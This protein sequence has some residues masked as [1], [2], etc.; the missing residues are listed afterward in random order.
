MAYTAPTRVVNALQLVQDRRY[1]HGI[2]EFNGGYYGERR[3][4]SKHGLTPKRSAVL[5]TIAAAAAWCDT[6]LAVIRP[7]GVTPTTTT[8]QYTQPAVGSTVVIAVASATGL[9]VG[10][11]VDVSTGGRYQITVIATLNITC[12]NIG[13]A[14]N[15]A[16]AAVVPTARTFTVVAGRG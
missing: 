4:T 2:R 13:G 3:N 14:G 7:T 15:A 8:A 9:V 1:T 6:D 5:T 12:L 11:T 10:Q 16:P